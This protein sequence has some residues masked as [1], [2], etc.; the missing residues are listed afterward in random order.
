[1][2]VNPGI[3]ALGRQDVFELYVHYF[4]S[5]VER[6][7]NAKQVDLTSKAQSDFDV[8]KDRFQELVAL[9]NSVDGDI[10]DKR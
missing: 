10:N 2:S 1:M 8:L 7:L 3:G 4:V 5:E 9:P 6:R